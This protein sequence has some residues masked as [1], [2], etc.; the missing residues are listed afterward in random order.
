MRIWS[1]CLWFSVALGFAQER[2]GEI[3]FFVVDPDG[4]G[5]AA[6]IDLT[7]QSAH[8]RRHF[9]TG[10]D[11]RLQSKGLPFGLYQA[12]VVRTGFAPAQAMVEVRSTV[13][14]QLHQ[15]LELVT[16]ATRIDVSDSATLIDPAETTS[17][18]STGRQALTESVSAQPGRSLLNLVANQPG[19]LYEANGV[20]HPRESEYGVQMIVDGMPMLENRSP[21]FAATLEASEFESVEVRTAGFPAEYGR[22]LGGVIELNTPRDLPPGFHGQV[23]VS[24]GSFDARSSA[25]NLSYA[26]GRNSFS[27]TGDVAT[28]SR[29]LDPAVQQNYTNSGTS[30][31][32]VAGYELNLDP[33]QRI[34]LGLTHRDAHF[35]VP[36]ELVQQTAG[37]RQ[38]R[39]SAES[40][41]Q[42]VYQKTWSD[43]LLNAQGSVRDES[44]NFWSN[45]NATPVIADQQRGFRQGYASI[46]LAGQ[47]GI[48]SWKVGADALFNDVHESLQYELTDRE[49][50]DPGTAPVFRFAES[51]P[52]REQALYA[53]DQ[54]RWKNWNL[55]AGLRFDHYGFLVHESGWSPRLSASRYFPALTLLVH[56]SYDRVFQTPAL[57]N[58]LLASSAQLNSISDAVVRLPVRPSRADY[59]EVG[60][61]KSVAS[62]LRVDVN[63]FQRSA[64]NFADDDVLL[65]TGVS[66][67]ISYSKASI[68]G[69]EA[70]LEVPK[71]GRLSGSLSYTNE[72]GTGR[73]PITGGLF[74]GSDISGISDSSS[75]PISQDERNIAR[76]SVRYQASTRIWISTSA[77]YQSGLP[78]EDVD[79]QTLGFLA[80]QYG[81]TVLDRVNFSASRVRPSFSWDAAAGWNIL[82]HDRRQI[83]AEIQGQNLTARLNVINFASLFSG[84]AIGPPS[85]V[86]VQ[87]RFTF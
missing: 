67:P 63:F 44:A 17:V 36:N 84:T 60:V 41:G 70:K 33:S 21:S 1:L 62:R 28:S 16:V 50:F 64:R 46:A 68:H 13:P 69:L 65:N 81:Q 71:W 2:K 78:V 80:S 15:G 40:S 85:S 76:G 57:E 7:S 29:Y 9:T 59:Y 86:L 3:D 58:L 11:G 53:Q 23:A 4:R 47:H 12:I 14:V 56:A 26:E 42:V 77:S 37:Q 10:V 31:G 73:G 20:L 8:V 66:F 72:T 87:V 45:S 24:G 38:D 75:F 5:I 61:T 55:G 51:K 32:V 35:D 39:S 49:M 83:S 30:D 74:L 25:A 18:Y 34:R 19:W 52:D 54:I 82:Q 22:K 6:D 79:P 43:I 48:H 27:L